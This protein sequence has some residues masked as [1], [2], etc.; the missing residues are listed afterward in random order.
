MKV[1]FKITFLFF[2]FT[3]VISF[4]QNVTIKGIAP[5][6]KGKEISVYLYDDL[7]TQSQTLQSSDTVD[8]RGNFELTLSIK[9][10]QIALVKTGNLT[11]SIYI[12]PNF[13]YGIIFPAKDS[14]RFN[15]GG[16]E[17]NVNLIINGDSTELNARIIDFNDC[18]DLFWEKNYKAFVSKQ[19]HQKLDSFQL[20]I[21]KRY[22]K[23]KL[24]YFKTYVDYT[25]ASFNENTGRHHNYLA[26]R[27]LL[28]KPIGYGN[29]EY[30][31]FFNQYF[32]QYIQ[33]QSNSKNGNLIIDAINEQGEYKHLNELLKGDPILKNDT[34]RELVALKS[35][36][37]LY[38]APHFK[39]GKIKE[40]LEQLQGS[41]T[42]TEHKTIVFDILRN[43]NNMRIGQM[44]P[45]FSLPNI[46]HDT[47]SLSDFKARY[48]Y[49][50]FFATWC[51]DC[52]QELKKQEQ[53]FRKYGD[54]VM[55]VS[56]CT[57]ND[58]MAFKN[59]VKQNPTYKWTFLY[60][61]KNKKLAEQYN[62]KSL[63]VYYFISPDGY[64]LQSPALKPDEGI[65]FKFNQIFKMKN[66]PKPKPN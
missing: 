55:F 9:S 61:G 63:P 10:T 5:T 23:V 42:I 46:K 11:G 40:M 15:A 1:Y 27:Y 7:I 28:D 50:N 52:L 6:H 4:A 22:E 25:F 17:Q 24:S 13:I 31:S 43:M 59:F 39:K 29:Y 41:T 37:D 57:D 3:S 34:L 36:S 56:V 48:T 44:A 2:L 21:N 32:K 35:L 38:F 30:M 20:Q 53:L 19:I 65:E 47:V 8:A 64:L 16:T 62:I 14:L 18:F 49:L 66:P 51:T 45:N 58:T 60:G 33:K 54:K 12:Q 26:K